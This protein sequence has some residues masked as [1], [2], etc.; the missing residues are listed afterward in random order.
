MAIQ[1]SWELKVR[2]WRKVSCKSAVVKRKLCVCRSYTETLII[3]DLKSV[4]RIRLVQTEKTESLLVINKCGKHRLCWNYLHFRV[5]C[6][7]DQQIYSPMQTP[8]IITPKSWQY[9]IYATGITFIIIRNSEKYHRI[10]LRVFHGL[11]VK[12]L[13][14]SSKT[15]IRPPRYSTVQHRFDFCEALRTRIL[16]VEAA[17]GTRIQSVHD[18]SM[19][20]LSQTE[21]A[22]G[23]VNY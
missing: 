21:D 9:L 23:L 15:K 2:L 12:N 17:I 7:G 11:S 6:T 13:R 19:W 16:A 22:A 8:S 4:F 3:I 20:L 5:V 14:N 1:F 10:Q 18:L